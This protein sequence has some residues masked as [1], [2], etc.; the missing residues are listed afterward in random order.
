MNNKKLET[1]KRVLNLQLK[2]GTA[3]YLIKLPKKQAKILAIHQTSQPIDVT[4]YVATVTDLPL[5]KDD[6]HFILSYKKL[7]GGNAHD[8]YK[9][10]LLALGINETPGNYTRAS[11]YVM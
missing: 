5:V 3:F 1:A 11:F 6:N 2:E 4:N 8:I 7:M 10:M 9:M